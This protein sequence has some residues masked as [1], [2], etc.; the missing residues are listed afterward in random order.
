MDKL[1]SKVQE[2]MLEKDDSIKHIGEWSREHETEAPE[3]DGPI[4]KL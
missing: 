4:G 2:L 3:N 1:K